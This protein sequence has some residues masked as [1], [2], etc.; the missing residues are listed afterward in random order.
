MVAPREAG[1]TPEP[2]W[3][4]AE[5]CISQGRRR[6]LSHTQ[7]SRCVY[8]SFGLLDERAQSVSS[9][10]LIA[11]DSLTVADMCSAIPDWFWFWFV[12]AHRAPNCPFFFV[13]PAPSH[14]RTM[15]LYFL[16]VSDINS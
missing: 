14:Y 2:A 10:V 13:E 1:A 4:R 12:V 5:T 9:F 11:T 3:T 7:V 6:Y 16:V 8:Y 15:N